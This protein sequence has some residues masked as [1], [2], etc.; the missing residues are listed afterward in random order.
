MGKAESG[1]ERGRGRL[2]G[3]G[4]TKLGGER[5]SPFHRE[6]PEKGAAKPT[7]GGVGCHQGGGGD[8]AHAW[9][10]NAGRHDFL[11]C[12]WGEPL[13]RSTGP[14][15]G[16]ANGSRMLHLTTRRGGESTILKGTEGT[17]LWEGWVGRKGTNLAHCKSSLGK[18]EMEGIGERPLRVREEVG[19]M[20]KR[21]GE[22]EGRKRKRGGE[23]GCR[24]PT[25]ATLIKRSR[26]VNLA[27]RLQATTG[28]GRR[29][30]QS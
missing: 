9:Q 15:N 1:G 21:T 10:K 3:C 25:A 7:V 27:Q 8:L 19:R 17:F 2:S 6:D 24:L 26:R 20:K 4:E 29:T 16:T 22:P 12:R 11:C 23:E 13:T 5:A 14:V 18:T 30:G 28:A